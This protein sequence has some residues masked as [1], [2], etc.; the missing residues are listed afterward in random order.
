MNRKMV[1]FLIGRILLL[2]SALLLLPLGVSL[3][4]WDGGQLP[5]LITIALSAGL[6]WL[7]CR[8]FRTD[9]QVIYAKEGFLITALTWVIVSALGAL[10]FVLS[11]QIPSFID[12]F[13]E[14][15]SGFTTTG[16]SILTDVEAM[17]RSMLFWRSFTHWI[18]GMGVLVLMVAVMPNLSGRTI[19]VLRAEMPGPTM[20]KLS[21]KLRDT[22]KIL[23]TL[24][25]AMTLLELVLLVAGGMPLFDSAIHTFG[26]AGT[27][28]FGMKADSIGSYSPYL[29]W[30]IAIFM[31]LFGVNF[32]LYFL[33]LMRRVKAAFRSEELWTYVGIV[34]GAT[35]LICW[36]ILPQMGSFSEAIRHAFFQVTTISSTTG[37]ATVNFDEWPTL[38]RMILVLL[39]FVGACAGSTAGGLK[40][41]RVVLLFKV[42]RREIRHLLHP[43]SVSSVRFEGK[44]VD[45]ATLISVGSYFALYIGLFAIFW[46]I[47]SFQPG[48]DGVSNFTAP[49]APASRAMM[50][51]PTPPPWPPATTTSARA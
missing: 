5:I 47:V 40:V 15:V 26:T 7:L 8:I 42:T 38:S 14:T 32:N 33:L 43:R 23:Y 11:G 29:Q 12:A 25:I 36:N 6:G 19:H 28:G 17:S 41:S 20:G 3:Y 1:Y 39:M 48:F 35:A 9:N 49:R 13:F 22:A 18:G 21:P 31:M 10:P 16:A 44:P 50:R 45:Q 51:S 27:G 24:Y 46:F 4:Y 2:E 34:L 30:I 37:F